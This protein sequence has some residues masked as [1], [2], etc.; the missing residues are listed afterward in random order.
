[1][2][3]VRSESHNILH[4]IVIR[5]SRVCLLF[6]LGCMRARLVSANRLNIQTIFKFVL[7]SGHG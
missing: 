4:I 6:V 5:V 3:K 7:D 1:M 2:V